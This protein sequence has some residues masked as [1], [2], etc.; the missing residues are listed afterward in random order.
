MPTDQ[1]GLMQN[2]KAEA[3]VLAHDRTGAHRLR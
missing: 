3:P 1:H 2:R